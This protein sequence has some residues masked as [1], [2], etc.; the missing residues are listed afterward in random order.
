MGAQPFVNLEKE[1]GMSANPLGELVAALTSRKG[2]ALVVPAMLLVGASLAV[3]KKPGEAQSVSVEKPLQL[4]QAASAPAPAAPVV[5]G[6]SS[7]SA[8]QRRDI[9]AIIKDYLINNPEV[10]VEIQT[11]LESKMEKIQGEKMQVSITENAKELF[12]SASAPIA[13]NPKGDVTV[14]E[15]FDYNC[16]YCKKALPELAE[17]IQKDKNVKVVLKEFP[18]L[19][20]ASEEAAKVALAAKMQGKYWEVHRGLLELQGQVNEASGL[21]VAEKLGLDLAR[22]K[23]DIGSAEVKKEIDDTRKLAQKMGIQGTPHFLVADKV[24]AGAPEDL[25]GRIIQLVNEVRKSGGCKVC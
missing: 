25:S 4:A 10:M 13:G 1:N 3:A 17:V 12:Q 9:E 11:A 23:K 19:S 24:I 7:F 2:L 18:I 5:S 14:V 6:K 16:G 22:L 21:K 8:E 15:F 20:K